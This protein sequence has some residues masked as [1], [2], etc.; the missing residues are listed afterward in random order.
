MHTNKQM[1]RLIKYSIT[2]T[3]LIT[4]SGSA[5][6]STADACSYNAQGQVNNDMSGAPDSCNADPIARKLSAYKVGLCTELPYYDNYQNVCDFLFESTT[7]I[8]LIAEKGSSKPIEGLGDVTLVEDRVYSHSVILASNTTYVKGLMEFDSPRLGKTGSGT[9]CWSTG[10]R[11]DYQRTSRSSF[12]AECGLLSE[13]NPE[14]NTTTNYRFA[15]VSQNIPAMERNF[16]DYEGGW[17][18]ELMSSE[19]EKATYDSGTPSWDGGTNAIYWLGGRPINPSVIATTETTNLDLKFS[20]SW[21]SI[22][23]YSGT[24]DGGN[25]H[26]DCASTPCVGAVSIAGFDLNVELN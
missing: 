17:T 2:T 23:H 11:D 15:H 9:Y 13:A 21:G 12:T 7:P 8:D 19:T 4:L 6:A 24:A 1:A 25:W 10:D 16:P 5:F 26:A 20:V 18:N 14:F 3:F 22:V